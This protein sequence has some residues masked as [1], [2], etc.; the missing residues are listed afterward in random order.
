MN[1][2]S[3]S[4]KYIIEK[5]GYTNSDNFYFYSNIDKCEELSFHDR[6]VLQEIAPCAFFVVQGKPKV[7]FFDYLNNE[8]DLKKLYRKIWNSQIPIIIFNDYDSIKVYNGSSIN[9]SKID[10]LEL[11]MMIE[12]ELE[13]CDEMSPF[14]YWNITNE[15]FL[16]EFE[17]YFSK[18]TLNR[19]M[20]KNIRCITEKLKNEYNVKFATKLI[21]RIIFIRFLIDRGVVIGYDGFNGDVEYNKKYLLEVAKNKDSLYK[22]FEYLKD[23]FN[24]NLFELGSEKDD[25]SLTDD[26]FCLLGRFLSGVEEMDSGQLS[27]L[28]LYDFNIIPIELISNIYEILLGEETQK[29]DKAFYTPEYL[30]DYIVKESVGTCLDIDT[31]CTVLDPACGS[32]IFLVQS[33][34]QIIS[35][36]VDSDGY[37]KDNKRLVEL[38][39]N[40][41]Y[42]VDLNPEAID[43]TIFSLYLTLF[44]YKDPKCLSGFKLP[45]LKNKNLFVSDFF[46]DDK[47]KDL[48]K[49]DFKF[50]IGNPPWGKV[51][52]GLHLKYCNDNGIKQ[53]RQEISRSF[54]AKVKDYS[55]EDTTCALVVPSKL[56]YNQQL[57]AIQFRKSLLKNSKILRVVEMS[58][59]R[60]LIFKEADAPAAIIFF[61]YSN[62][63]CLGNNMIHISLK[64][65]MFFKLYNIIAMEKHD[66]KKIQQR[67]L[68][69]N[70]WAWK[71]CVYG[72][73]WDIDNIRYLKRNFKS[74]NEIF[75][76]NKLET[77][78]G[79]SD[80]SGSYDATCH[81]GRKII[82]ATSVNTFFYDGSNK[83]T[84]NKKMVHRIGK[85]ELYHPPY[86]L[87]RKGPNCKTY[88]LRAAF[89]DD[90]VIFKQAI[91]AIKGT[92]KQKELLL[93]IVGILNS[94]L[95]AYLNLMLGSSMGIEREQVFMNEVYE[96]PFAYS[97]EIGELT[98]Q[99]Q[100]IRSVEAG[101]YLNDAS[102]EIDYLD[103]LVLEEF[104]LKNNS[105]IDYALN[106]QIP[107]INS[108]KLGYKEVTIETLTK[109]TEIFKEYWKPMME[110]QGKF[111]SMILYPKVMNKFT[112]FELRV[113][114][115]KPQKEIS[116]E[117][118]IDNNKEI[119]SRFMINK[120]NEQFYEIKDVVYFEDTSFYI[121]K[122]NEHKNWHV[123]RAYL[124]NSTVISS[125][126]SEK[127]GE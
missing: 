22:F 42:G 32:G 102:K 114:N 73:D 72:T 86:C 9:L 69:E 56:F 47:L 66:L 97:K 70:D 79:I 121:I 64:P 7:L 41:I 111:I 26:V 81:I 103:N 37:I 51:T 85:T 101:Q 68:Y 44:D 40:N 100:N 98:K 5:L 113:Y 65:N 18:D 108:S 80:N 124:D 91:S 43:V 19:V 49:I 83:A 123:A 58:S 28:P 78:A 8:R 57:P 99:I 60:K 63:N 14:S 6:K 76:E 27:F 87:M 2:V 61:K 94:S 109:Y 50:I 25:L 117:Y 48:K 24:G 45:N 17:D 15:R 112:I 46:D 104:G 82:E 39:E 125:I 30:A 20:I 52:T 120:I 107:M 55:K 34:K 71:V 110:Q 36:N 4:M 12:Q 33:L 126:L 31:N 54:I 11:N 127:Q 105:F 84:F 1:Q 23:K 115:D 106:V 116:I 3:N 77:A 89:V 21:L 35:K 16:C 67:M 88:R 38:V 118:N 53:Q 74:L 122:T 90:D 95:Y 29:K 92:E 62:E 93:N 119:L 96:Y 10:N 75:L 13:K 59:V